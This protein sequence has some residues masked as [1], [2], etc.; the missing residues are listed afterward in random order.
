MF[1]D[2][3]AWT[4]INFDASASAEVM[5]S[6]AAP[7]DAGNYIQDYT[8]EKSPQINRLF[9]FF[10]SEVLDSTSKCKKFI[11]FA[12]LNGLQE[13]TTQNAA[14]RE[15]LQNYPEALCMVVDVLKAFVGVNPSP[16]L[17]MLRTNHE[18][19]NV[20]FSDVFLLPYCNRRIHFFLRQKIT[21]FVTFS[22]EDATWEEA[23]EILL[24]RLYI[25]FSVTVSHESHVI[26]ME[27]IASVLSKHVPTTTADV[28]MPL[29]ILASTTNIDSP[30]LIPRFTLAR[31]SIMHSLVK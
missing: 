21:D 23:R 15:A 22:V 26:Y 4:T 2:V 17:E 14:F 30:A 7:T 9:Q 3:T 24:T 13:E 1:V 6:E 16:K 12:L 27:I 8:R 31:S 29:D 10:E 18:I 28:V 5:F 20:L 19:W 25:L 11:F